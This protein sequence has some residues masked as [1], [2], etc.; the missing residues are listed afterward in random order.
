MSGTDRIFIGRA[1]EADAVIAQ[2]QAADVFF[3][4]QGIP[5]ERCAMAPDC[6][7][8]WWC[9]K[10]DGNM[11]GTVAAYWEEGI[12]H[13][14]RITIA[15]ELRGKHIGTEMLRFAMED[16]FASVTDEIFMEARE[17]TV[18]I[19]KKM[20]AQITGEPVP[21]YGGTI[22]PLILNKKDFKSRP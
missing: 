3:L 15:P 12:C 5:R 1:S 19:M 14:G 6:N 16:L 4:E 20:G 13:V 9:V 7:P 21:F 8:I 22:T 11:V 10:Q 17:T 18:H 2:K